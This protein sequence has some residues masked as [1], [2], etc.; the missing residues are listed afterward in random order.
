MSLNTKV[1]LLQTVNYLFS[2]LLLAIIYN[3][4]EY[5]YLIY[6]LISW[7]LI[8]HVS[9]IIT[10]HRLLTHRSFKTYKWLEK[11]LSYLS[12]FSTVGPTISWVALH[13]FHHQYSDNLYDPH[14]P[15]ID[16]KFS[17][18]QALKVFFG[19]DWHITNIPIGYVKDLMRS[20]THKF[21][22][23]NYFKIIFIGILILLL[24]DPLLVLY[25]YCL[26]ATLTVMTIG[27]VNVFGHGHGYRN[28]NTSDNSTNS[29]FASLI[30]LGEGWHN[31][32]HKHPTNYT[33]REK[34]YELDLMGLV[35]KLI[36]V[37]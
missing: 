15:Y 30:T 29:W 2:V 20:K 19:Y 7:F 26:P 18:K 23:N 17:I 36:R 32:H 22:F 4:G 8:G 5:S 3:T 1:R 14:S 37:K 28:H 9:T 13:R 16:G 10:L 31:N 25:V 12:V 34:Y 35:I 24:I 6:T 33:T 21:I 27:I 11:F